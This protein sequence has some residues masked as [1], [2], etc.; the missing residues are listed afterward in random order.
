[1]PPERRRAPPQLSLLNTRPCPPS[2]EFVLD[3][4]PLSPSVL[5][6][7]S[8][9]IAFRW[10]HMDPV[11]FADLLIVF[12]FNLHGLFTSECFFYDAFD[13]SILYH[14]YLF[15][16]YSCMSFC[17]IT[18]ILLSCIIFP[19]IFAHLSTVFSSMIHVPFAI[20]ILYHWYLF[21]SYVFLHE[22]CNNSYYS[23]VYF[24]LSPSFVNSIFL[25]DVFWQCNFISLIFVL[26]LWVSALLLKLL[27][28]VIIMS[29][30][31]PSFVCCIFLSICIACL[32]VPLL[33]LFHWVPLFL[34]HW[35][36][37][38]FQCVSALKSLS[39]LIYTIGCSIASH[40][41]FLSSCWSYV[42]S[43]ALVCCCNASHGLFSICLPF[44]IY[45]LQHRGIATCC[46][47]NVCTVCH[48]YPAALVFFCVVLVFSCLVLCPQYCI[49]F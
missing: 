33:M 38:C 3:A 48:V 8:T 29:L 45:I 1:M 18:V 39:L 19:F 20:S 44:N 9:I 5:Q 35:S 23:M 26:F 2:I 13:F 49:L 43:W 14:W 46:G 27:S 40:G 7:F 32:L 16:S 37:F 31:F 15:H 6:A 10:Q 47:D 41:G 21:C 42:R 34:Y 17:I 22:Y 12:S 28:C 11:C 25:D 4:M 24:P 30:C 36:L